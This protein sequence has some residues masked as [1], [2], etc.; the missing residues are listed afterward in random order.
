MRFKRP[1]PSDH[2]FETPNYQRP[3][4]DLGLSA[5][6]HSLSAYGR[7]IDSGA[8]RWFDLV[9]GA[10]LDGALRQNI[11]VRQVHAALTAG[12][13]MVRAAFFASGSLE[14]F[15]SDPRFE[16]NYAKAHFVG[17]VEAVNSSLLVAGGAPVN[18]P[19]AVMYYSLG[20]DLYRPYATQAMEL[21]PETRAPL[22]KTFVLPDPFIFEV[23]EALTPGTL[24]DN[25][26]AAEA[27]G[28][29]ADIIT[30]NL[31]TGSMVHRGRVESI[32]PDGPP[33]PGPG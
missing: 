23:G 22:T 28:T 21:Q 4:I 15:E 6:P 14:S 1:S 17:T 8:T 5:T 2:F 32:W 11:D 7:D 25:L 10:A 20:N 19:S 26:R 24:P 12:Q 16:I 3:D 29:L 13:L 27:L 9:Y 30:F 33:G 18:I 31:E